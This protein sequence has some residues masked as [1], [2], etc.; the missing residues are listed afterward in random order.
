MPAVTAMADAPQK[1]TRAVAFG[2][3]TPPYAGAQHV[4]SSPVRQPSAKLGS[5]CP[6]LGTIMAAS[7]RRASHG[8]QR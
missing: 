7:P 3:A 4:V 5:R 8:F 1:A 6:L 2:I